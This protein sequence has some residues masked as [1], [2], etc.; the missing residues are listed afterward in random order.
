MAASKNTVSLM[1]LT[2]LRIT[3][4]A[5]P[6]MHIQHVFYNRLCLVYHPISFA[7]LNTRLTLLHCRLL[8]VIISFSFS[9]SLHLGRCKHCSLAQE[10]GHGRHSESLDQMDCHWQRDIYPI[11]QKTK[12]ESEYR[13]QRIKNKKRNN[14]LI[15]H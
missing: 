9:F 5:T 11:E 13:N 2:P 1:C 14:D 10:C 4:R 12:G 3:A 15:A 8:M 7:Q 6:A